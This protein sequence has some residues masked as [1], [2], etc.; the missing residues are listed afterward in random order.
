M[1][2]VLKRTPAERD[3]GE[4]PRPLEPREQRTTVPVGH[5]LEGDRARHEETRV[6]KRAASPATT[7]PEA[8]LRGQTLGEF[9]LLT[10]LGEDALGSVYRA[11]RTG[12]KDRLVRLRTLESAELSPAAVARAVE[13]NA[14]LV[15]ALSHRAIVPQSELG[16]VHRVPYLAWNEPTGWTL[17]RVLSRIRARGSRIPLPYALSIADRVAAGLE[18]AW[19]TVQDGHPTAH[20]LLWPGFVVIGGDAEVQVGGFGLADAVL[21]SLHRP[22]L[23]REIAP[24][25]APEA[26]GEA[27][28]GSNADVYSLGALMVELL[29]SRRPSPDSPL[30]GLPAEQDFPEEIAALLRVSL[31]SP[32]ER[33]PSVIATRRV[34]QEALAASPKLASGADLALYFYRL[35]NPESTGSGFPDAD[36]GRTASSGG[37]S[38]PAKVA[39]DSGRGKAARR[40]HKEPQPFFQSGIRSRQPSASVRLEPPDS[41]VPPT[42]PERLRPRRHTLQTAALL[43]IAGASVAFFLGSRFLSLPYS[44]LDTQEPTVLAPRKPSAAARGQAVARPAGPAASAPEALKQ[45]VGKPTNREPAE[46]SWKKPAEDSRFKAALARVEAERLDA[47]AAGKKLF[48]QGKASEQDGERLLRQQHYRAAEQA[49]Q[50]ATDRFHEAE[51]ASR[52]ERVRKIELSAGR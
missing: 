6:R 32:E 45:T 17:D 42:P 28:P 16:I 18:A 49:F 37:S 25:I 33:F 50:A 29:T 7:Q 19:L 22:R 34:L 5:R 1:P 10:R 24:Y 8:K 52:E 13:Q 27:K 20:G 51:S 9:V 11:L 48:S 4:Q 3:S 43:A 46:L 21:P 39:E 14:K 47:T 15:A 35:L 30:A 23:A 41:L 31:A 26:R 38:E 44:W 12:E 36:P 2:P 40:R